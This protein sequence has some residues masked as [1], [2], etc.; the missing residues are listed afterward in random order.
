MGSGSIVN[1]TQFNYNA[2]GQLITHHQ[3]RR[4]AGSPG[5]TDARSGPAQHAHQPL[6]GLEEP[7]RSLCP[8]AGDG[9]ACPRRI[10]LRRGAVRLLHFQVLDSD[11]RVVGNQLTW[12]YPRAS[13]TKSC[14]GCHEN[15]HT[16]PRNH[17]PAA[18]HYAPVRFLPNGDELTYRAKA[19]MKGYLPPE[20]EERM[21]TVRAVNLLARWTGRL[22]RTPAPY[23]P[24]ASERDAGSGLEFAP[25]TRPG[26]DA[27][28]L[29]HAAPTTFPPP[30]AA[31]PSP[32]QSGCGV[33]LRRIP[34]NGR[35]DGIRQ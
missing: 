10:V 6:A 17:R 32:P 5:G 22:D 31:R 20:V 2:F 7:P 19:W 26:E 13:E 30:G 16:T 33:V 28:I 1:E 11:R 35:D 14:V 3:P 25:K 18:A 24:A 9:A 21:R 29:T 12:I 4:P 34:Q 23:R 27:G 8:R 15:P